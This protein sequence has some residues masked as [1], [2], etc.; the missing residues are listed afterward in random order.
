MIPSSRAHTFTS[1][2]S[3]KIS[4][5]KALR[6]PKL[7]R[8]IVIINHL[9][10]TML[11][12]NIVHI[13]LE[14]V[15]TERIYD[16]IN[17]RIKDICTLINTT[18]HLDKDASDFFD[19]FQKNIKELSHIE[20]MSIYNFNFQMCQVGKGK[21]MNELRLLL[22]ARIFL[23]FNE[24]YDKII[25]INRLFNYL[26]RYYLLEQS[27]K[28]LI[29]ENSFGEVTISTKLDDDIKIIN[30]YIESNNILKA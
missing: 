9:I 5:S 19:I 7:K 14:K 16:K 18:L 3:E 17:N 8:K 22:M 28:T 29:Y 21:E 1:F 13:I 12:H 2:P 25:S 10:I 30:N 26:Y 24:Y 4:A 23:K 6:L 27:N 11:N 20:W 15:R